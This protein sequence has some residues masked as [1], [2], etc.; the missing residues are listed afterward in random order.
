M[1]NERDFLMGAYQRNVHNQPAKCNVCR[2][3]YSDWPRKF[4]KG[5]GEGPPYDVYL[6]ATCFADHVTYNADK[7]GYKFCLLPDISQVRV[8]NTKNGNKR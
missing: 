3:E 7:C 5:N 2:Q 6:C 4:L 1:E 8:S